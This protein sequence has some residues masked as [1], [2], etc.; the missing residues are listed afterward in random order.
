MELCAQRGA[1][2]L[3]RANR[4]DGRFIPGYLPALQKTVEDDSYLRQAAAAAALARA[5]RWSGDERHLARAR[6]AVLTLL[7]DTAADPQDPRVRFT[8]LPSALVNRLGAAG[9]LLLAIHELPSP[10][11]DLLQQ[12]D[13]LCAFVG[14]QQRPNGSLACAESGP[15]GEATGD[16]PS[17]V[18]EY[19]GAA[20]YGLARSQA[21]RPASWKTDVLRKALA[22][23]RACWGDH[24]DTALVPWQTAAFAEACVLTK[25]P[26]FAEF[27]FELSDWVCGLQYDRLDPRHP[28]WLGGFMGWA[29]GKP[30]PAE[31][32]VAAALFAEG[33]AEACRV[34]RQRG[35]LARH[36]RY[37]AALT[38]ALQFVTTLQYTEA[39]TSHFADWYR[40][41]LFGGFHLSHQDGT[42][43]LDHTAHAVSALVQYVG[44][45]AD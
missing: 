1:E 28:L 33:L 23:D 36:A 10:G 26:A 6:Q 15:N 4:P 40:P 8:T 24:R 17:V 31:P 20:L 14:R 35:D 18:E 19:H 42:L 5:A 32:T 30:D 43:R 9:L 38:R 41:T 7:L 13:Q 2:W 21:H 3:Y 44:G 25:E 22:C 12:S 27:V 29:G 39:N 45:A 11:A 34:A 16:Q 37:A